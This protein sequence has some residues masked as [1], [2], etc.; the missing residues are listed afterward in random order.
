MSKIFCIEF[1]GNERSGLDQ[2]Y[3]QLKLN[4]AMCKSQL[5]FF[6]KY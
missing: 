5:K 2:T 1:M 4:T 3:Y 6:R